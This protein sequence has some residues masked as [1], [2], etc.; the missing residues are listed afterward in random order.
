[1]NNSIYEVERN[2]YVAFLGQLKKDCA[3]LEKYEDETGVTIKLI[4]IKTG[5][6]LTTRVIPYEGDEKYYIFNYPDADERQEPKAIRQITLES[7]EEVQA[8]F[9]ILNKIQKGE[10]KND[11]TVS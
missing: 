9:D 4:S 7:Q 2:D 11:R 8:F 10:L 3:D 1:M 6:H 5:K